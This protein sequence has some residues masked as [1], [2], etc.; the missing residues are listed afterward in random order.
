MKRHCHISVLL[1]LVAI[2]LML[3]GCHHTPGYDSRLVE[4]DSLVRQ[5]AEQALAFLKS[6]DGKKLSSDADRAYHALLLTQARYRCYERATS[7]STINLALDY[8][9]RHP[10]EIEKLTRCYIFKGGVMEEL[11]REEEA[12][13]NY[14]RAIDVAQPDDH[15]NQG[16]ARLRLANTYRDNQIADS[17]DIKLF[18]EALQHFEA[19]PDSFYILTCL[20]SIGGSYIRYNTDNAMTHLQRADTLAKR[21]GI[22]SLE[23]ETLI[24]IADVKMYSPE[25]RDIEAAKGIA[26]S[27]L[28]A[29]DCPTERKDHLLMIAALTLAKQHK[30]DSAALYFNQV[31]AGQLSDGLRV[32]Y[33]KCLAEMAKNRGDIEAFQY[34]C[35]NYHQLSDSISNNNNQMRLRDIEARYDNQQLKYK[36]MRYRSRLT[37]SILAG[38]L[39]ASLLAIALMLIWRKAV[40]RKQRLLQAE[41]TIDRMHQDL[42]LL[43]VRLNTEQEMNDN[44]K[45]AIQ[46]QVENFSRLVEMHVTQSDGKHKEFDRLFKE[47][48]LKGGPDRSFWKGLSAYA[49]SRLN[50]IISKTHEAYPVLKDSDLNFLSLYCLSMP[51]TVIMACMGYQDTHSFYNKRRRI[52]EKM[53]LENSL[54]EYIDGFRN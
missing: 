54:E 2:V 1:S 3:A 4:A 45:E 11:G 40:R 5:D 47:S 38:L 53:K 10:E 46:H 31:N 28:N 9:Q 25:A 44:L 41:E 14:K 52:A 51:P 49:N 19:V 21:L 43:E 13:I 33:G 6:L 15:Y 24:Y 42:A 20:S 35:D 23:Q 27:L 50:N 8:Y 32:F 34:Y 48:Y 16:Y 36:N 39:I 26:L 12:I 30:T 7:D 29:A 22:R 18:K 37:I 17:A